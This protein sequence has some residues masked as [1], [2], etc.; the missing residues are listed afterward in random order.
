MMIDQEVGRLWADHHIA[1][2]RWAKEA[3]HQVGEAFRVLARV[4][5]DRPWE[6][7]CQPR[8]IVEEPRTRH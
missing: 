8:S 6:R 2:G 4:Q 5:Y 7:E 3:V 1:F